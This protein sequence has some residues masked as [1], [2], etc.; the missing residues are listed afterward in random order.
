MNDTTLH[1][2]SF[3]AP[4]AAILQ[5]TQTTARAEATHRRQT[6]VTHSF[7]NHCTITSQQQLFTL[8]KKPCL[9]QKQALFVSKTSLVCIK[10]KPC[11]QS[12][13]A[14]FENRRFPIR[15]FNTFPWKKSLFE[16]KLQIN[17]H[18]SHIVCTFAPLLQSNGM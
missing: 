14:L 2:L 6:T 18:I 11:L 9:Y 15:F 1:S 5:E 10:K 4:T 3:S 7:T 13:E 12:K 17:L 8:E 16:K